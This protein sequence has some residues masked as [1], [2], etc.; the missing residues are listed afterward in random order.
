MRRIN[1]YKKMFNVE[2]GTDLKQLK[3]TYRSLVKKWHPDKFQDDDSKKA[4]AAH[5]LQEC[6][7]KMDDIP[8]AKIMPPPSSKVK[9]DEK[10]DSS[11]AN[12]RELQQELSEFLSES[13]DQAE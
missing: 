7:Q 11:S 13:F 12:P 9:T 4:E 1:E 10:E 8:G 5:L 6:I 2:P 3:T